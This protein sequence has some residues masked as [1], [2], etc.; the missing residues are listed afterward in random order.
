[1]L[2]LQYL[3]SKDLSILDKL[4]P[5]SGSYFGASKKEFLKKISY[6]AGQINLA[7]YS[8]KLK[9]IKHKTQ[10][11]TYFLIHPEFFYRNKFILEE[12]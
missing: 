3:I 6:I 5:N 1:M 10:L 12:V 11:N 4:L 9:F 2:F 8:N 7:G